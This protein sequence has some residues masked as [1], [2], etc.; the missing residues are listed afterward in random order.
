MQIVVNVEQAKALAKGKGRRRQKSK[1][2]SEA[3]WLDQFMATPEMEPAE[4]AKVV[5]ATAKAKKIELTGGKVAFS[6]RLPLAPTVD[7]FMIPSKHNP[8]I[9]IYT[10]EARAYKKAVET[11]WLRHCG[12]WP[13]D[14]VGGRLRV[15]VA[16]HFRR[17]G[18]ADIANREKAASDALT[19]CG[20]W[21]DDSLIGAL[22]LLRGTVVPRIGAMDVLVEVLG[23][24][25]KTLL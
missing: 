5:R 1:G 16:V 15:A 7:H 10:A 11:M 17:G 12:G 6:I 25:Q 24:E 18:K 19:G 3:E 13:P 21:E 4:V 2:K 9:W 22:I 20:A 8:R 23:D 14:P